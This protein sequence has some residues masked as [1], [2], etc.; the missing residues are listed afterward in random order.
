MPL[1]QEM[2]PLILMKLKDD[3]EPIEGA[4]SAWASYKALSTP[5]NLLVSAR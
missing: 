4:L 1:L 5:A 2:S 3:I